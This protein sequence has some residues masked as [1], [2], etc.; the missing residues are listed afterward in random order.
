MEHL[1]VSANDE[2]AIGYHLVTLEGASFKDAAW[3]PGQKLQIAIGSPSLA[4]TYTPIEW[5]PSTGRV[6]IL[7]YARGT[8]P[9]SAWLRGARVTV[10][11]IKGPQAP[12]DLD[13]KMTGLVAFFGDETSIG[14]AY[15]L[16]HRDRMAWFVGGFEVDDV[17]ACRTVL[18]DLALHNFD[19]IAREPG[20]RHIV[21]IEESLPALAAEC[22]FVLTGKASTVERL[23]RRLGSLGVPSGRIV[24]RNYWA[25][26][27]AGLD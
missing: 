16:A 6:C 11:R 22:S 18:S 24:A 20:D 5:N 19:L 26:D 23:R 21:R 25:P 7:G 27:K 10:A 9:G 12:L 15:A 8:G 2:L 17:D 13:Q 1:N 14:L 4:R 3:T